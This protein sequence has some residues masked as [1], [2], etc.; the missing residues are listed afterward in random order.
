MESDCGSG[1][2]ARLD[3]ELNGGLC[4]LHDAGAAGLGLVGARVLWAERKSRA[5]VLRQERRPV[6]L[7]C[8]EFV[9]GQAGEVRSSGWGI[10]AR[11]EF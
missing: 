5:M 3:E 6:W 4:E 9:V 11:N 1:R 8:N 2:G 10:P 7:D